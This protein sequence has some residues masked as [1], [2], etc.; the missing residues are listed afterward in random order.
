MVTSLQNRRG[1]RIRDSGR[2]DHARANH[3]NGTTHLEDGGA[4]EV[5]LT[6]YIRQTMS[7]ELELR[8]NEMSAAVTPL[9]QVGVSKIT[10]PVKRRR[11]RRD[12]KQ[13]RRK[14]RR[15]KRN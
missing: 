10:S 6:Q 15:D 11:D 14:D 1:R 8:R 4:G 5:W 2:Q 13:D 12:E 7:V 3:P 9:T